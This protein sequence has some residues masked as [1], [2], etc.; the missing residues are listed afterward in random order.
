MISIKN[1]AG[2]IRIIN[3]IAFQTNILALN[4]AVEAARAGEHGKGF[5]VVAAEVRKLAERSKIAADEINQLSGYGVQITEE[6]TGLLNSIIPQI[7]KTTRLIQE[8][9]SASTEQSAGAEQVNSA[10]Q[11]LN[12]VTQHNATAS[13]EMSSSAEQMTGQARQLKELI[14]YF[15][16]IDAELQPVQPGTRK[17]E[18]EEKTWKRAVN[19]RTAK[20]KNPSILIAE[21]IDSGFKRF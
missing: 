9:S 16:M 5:A 4:A 21:T 2:K 12:N 18:N 14:A 8:I 19:A 17:P 7:E 11:Q 1:I 20:K 15:K 3:D 13:E 10:M 6:S